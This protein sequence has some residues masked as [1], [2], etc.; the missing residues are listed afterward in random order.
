METLRQTSWDNYSVLIH[1]QDDLPVIS[2]FSY[3][4]SFLTGDAL[5]V[6]YGLSV[7]EKNFEIACKLLLDRYGRPE[8]I[9]F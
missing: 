5:N 7:T 1:D 3:L 4:T 2:K 9:I 8:K 6:V